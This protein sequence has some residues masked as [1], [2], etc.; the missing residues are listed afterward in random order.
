MRGWGCHVARAKTVSAG[1]S[2]QRRVTSDESGA[3]FLVDGLEDVRAGRAIGGFARWLIRFG[4]RIDQW[5]P[6]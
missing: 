4:Q 2:D 6:A 3:M 1:I 5:H